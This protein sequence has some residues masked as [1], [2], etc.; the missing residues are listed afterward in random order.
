MREEIISVQFSS[1]A[2]TT[3]PLPCMV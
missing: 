2:L 1:V 3:W